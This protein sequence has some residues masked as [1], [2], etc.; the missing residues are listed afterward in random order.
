MTKADDKY[1]MKR[2][3]A[4]VGMSGKFPQSENIR[5]FWK[6]LV[7]EKELVHFFT[8]KE[9]DDIGVAKKQIENSSF[10]KA[11]A[12]IDSS[13]GFDYPFFKYTLDE[14]K[15]MNPQTRL[16]HQLVWTALEDAGC[17]IEKYTKKIGVFVGANKDLN[18]NLYSA[19]SKNENV[20]FLMKNKLIDPNFM[21]SLISYKLNFRGPCY[22]LDTACSTSL[23]TNH[24]GC[25]SLLLG[26]CGIAVVGGIRLLSYD[27]NGYMYHKGSIMSGDGHTKS[28][29]SDASG[30]VFSDG[31]GVVI[32]KK[33]E[34]AIADNDSI[35]AV[36]KSSAM[37]NDGNSKAG[38]TMPSVKGQSD[39]IKLA[40]RIAGVSPSDISYVETHGTGT[41]IGDPIE[42]ESLNIAFNNDTAHKCAIGTV[43]SNMGHADEA[44]GIAGL[45][46][47]SLALKHKIIPASLHYKKPNPTIDFDEG[48]FYVN[49][50]SQK[51]ERKNDKP[52]TAGVSSFGIGG[53]NLHTILQEVPLFQ[54]TIEHSKYKL[55]RYSANSLESLE[56]Y[57]LKLLNFLTNEEKIDLSNLAY[58]LQAGRKQFDYGKYVVVENVKE[59]KDVLKSKQ[60]KTYEVEVKDNVVFMFSGQGS[61]YLNMGK[62]LYEEYAQ[63]K[64][65]LDEGFMI[66]KDLMGID[67]KNILF[68][69]DITSPEINDTLNTQP[70]LFLFEYGLAQLLR[71]FGVEPDYL[72][73]HSLGEYVAACISGVFSFEDALRI[74]S[75]RAALMAGVCKGYMLSVGGSIR[76][77]DTSV[78]DG[79]SIAAI[80]SPDSFVVSGTAG[81]ISSVKERLK[82][83]EIPYTALKTSHAFHSDLMKGILEEFEKEL[84]T[85]KFTE[86]GI[87]F[88]SNT[89]GDFIT[90]DQATSTSYWKNHIIG[91]V[92]FEKGIKKLIQINYS[93]FIEIGPGKTLTTFFKQCQDP[94]LQNASLNTIRHPKEKVNDD[95]Y[96]TT[97]LGNLW[98]Y[99][100]DINWEKY[101]GENKPYKIPAPTY[102]FDVY[103]VPVK[104]SIEE[105]LQNKVLSDFKKKEVSDCF[106]IL[107]WKYVPKVSMKDENLNKG[108]DYLLFMDESVFSQSLKQKLKEKNKN[109]IEVVK[110]EEFKND[111]PQK[112]T[113]NPR[114][115]DDYKS[116]LDQL[117]TIGFKLDTIVYSW[118]L[119]KETITK[120]EY[121][122]FKMYN[123]TFENV[124][125]I[126]KTFRLNEIETKKNFV[127]ISNTN[128]RVTGVEKVDTSSNHVG[129]FLKVLAQESSNLYAAN[130]DLDVD[131]NAPRYVSEI[132]SEF[133][134]KEKYYKVAYRNG[135]RWVPFYEAIPNYKANKKE[136]LSTKGVYL[137]TGNL[138]EIG[139]VLAKYLTEYYQAAVIVFDSKI[140]DDESGFEMR[141]Q[142]FEN[143]KNVSHVECD[144]TDYKV[145]SIKVEK[146]EKEYGMI[147]GVIHAARNINAD[148]L[149]LAN[150]IT[151]DIIDRHFSLK[152]NG[153]LAIN[154]V[155]KEKKIDF[156]K[157]ISSISSFLGGVFYGAYAA[158]SA[159]MDDLTMYDKETSTNWSVINLD[160]IGEEDEWI[161]TKELAEIF[162]YSLIHEGLNQLIVSKR[163]INS[164]QELVSK[165]D[166]KSQKNAKI[167]RKSLKSLFRSPQSET[168]IKIIDLFEDL[169]GMKG[170]GVEDNF[171][172]LGGDSLKGIPLINKINKKFSLNISL[173]DFFNNPTVALLSSLIDNR[174]WLA[175]KPKTKNE[176]FI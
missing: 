141:K 101:Y 61:Q 66:L 91:T 46:K 44:A 92:D 114:S 68:A 124:H 157:V 86:P 110:G 150:N 154:E 43:K 4:I 38:Y 78:L 53:T 71:G 170:I 56:N 23:S 97:F 116:L 135:R 79:V 94:E 123:E 51:W 57:E 161:H 166:S 22:F 117:N 133:G 153:V 45:I 176:I 15:L 128:C 75:K 131:I 111:L 49:S 31:A 2:D 107:S 168:E 82:E 108:D 1:S 148:D 175:I 139:Y 69:E 89:T 12:S 32:L 28:F 70:I 3:I 11:A 76:T 63:F 129:V 90:V 27:D 65:I 17:N 64:E 8:D 34:E 155:F 173:T 103:D 55:I 125:S 106:T 7:D 158:G 16:M 152:V 26:E 115:A 59:L 74:V 9:L 147:N 102:A 21:A 167:N 136:V 169:F 62:Q 80:N 96:F 84:K 87:P 112:I 160:R 163:D 118:E 99:G 172:E 39:C 144:V 143:L 119:G 149:K 58:T 29:D 81:Q 109:V 113:I 25:R 88:I 164:K 54:K 50:V 42:I 52:L 104:V 137:I 134:G 36:I 120:N 24:L 83:K 130:I 72:I 19:L 14:A 146:I 121:P 33:L 37:N 171:F 40:Q 95:F 20:D 162:E 5:E 174:K 140:S 13:H 60:V 151:N 105:K 98:K 100:I 77:I 35:Y 48:P 145:F 18:W 159:L 165:K 156:I 142:R 138:D 127:F 122:D 126:I 30:T 10:I 73:G 67:Y 47:T 132:L 6:N 93:L 85:I 41:K